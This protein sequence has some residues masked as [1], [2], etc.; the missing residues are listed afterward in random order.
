MHLK[1]KIKNIQDNLTNNQNW[2]SLKE[3]FQN[4][5]KTKKS[6]N[7]GNLNET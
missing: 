3:L 7:G 6:T 2:S 4:F 5:F 1:L